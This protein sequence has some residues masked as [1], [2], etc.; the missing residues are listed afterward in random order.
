MFGLS[1]EDRRRWDDGARNAGLASQRLDDHTQECTRR[2]NALDKGL[3]D[4]SNA[5]AT[6]SREND[7]WNKRL[8]VGLVT[9]LLAIL[10]WIAKDA[11]HFQVHVG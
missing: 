1:R 11:V 3:S 10:G 6:A 8:M 9:V 7:K 5:L 4:L 2:Y